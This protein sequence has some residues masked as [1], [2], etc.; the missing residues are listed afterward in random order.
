MISYLPDNP[1][2]R[3]IRITRLKSLITQCDNWFQL[4]I[5]IVAQNWKE[6]VNLGIKNSKIFL[7][8]YT[9]KLGITKARESLREKFI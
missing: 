2:L 1:E 3:E 4:P 8:S 9:N 6:D 7:Y 5:I